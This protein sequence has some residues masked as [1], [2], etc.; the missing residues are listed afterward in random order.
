M[1]R[2]TPCDAPPDVLKREISALHATINDLLVNP[3]VPERTPTRGSGSRRPTTTGK[4]PTSSP[5]RGLAPAGSGGGR[6]SSTGEVADT[7]AGTGTGDIQVAVGN[8]MRND[9]EHRPEEV[10]HGLGVVSLDPLIVA[11]MKKDARAAGNLMGS[12][13]AAA[14][15]IAISTGRHFP[16]DTTRSLPRIPT[17][18]VLPPPT[19]TTAGRVTG[20]PIRFPKRVKTGEWIASAGTPCEI[21]GATNASHG[22]D[23][24]GFR[25]YDPISQAKANCFAVPNGY[26]QV[27]VPAPPLCASGVARYPNSL[28]LGAF[29]GHARVLD[30]RWSTSSNIAHSGDNLR[31]DRSV[32]SVT[33]SRSTWPSVGRARVGRP[34]SEALYSSDLKANM[35]G[36]VQRG[37][38]RFPTHP[39]HPVPQVTPEEKEVGGFVSAFDDQTEAHL[40][41]CGLLALV[42]KIPQ[43]CDSCEG[44]SSS[45]WGALSG[46]SYLNTDEAFAAFATT[47]T[48]EVAPGGQ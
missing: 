30:P 8:P 42:L 23:R 35:P 44:T 4:V 32:Q 48:D 17:P 40:D 5:T 10:R 22:M 34:S 31:L 18:M 33:E 45:S 47:T 38:G 11:T 21:A 24:R 28:S 2:D 16:Q 26:L 37:G 9:W 12:T 1:P 19:T 15:A 46:G 7:G 41:D 14:A 39:P 20:D 13:A 6:S 3:N 25:G 29:E 36:P 43:A 27:A